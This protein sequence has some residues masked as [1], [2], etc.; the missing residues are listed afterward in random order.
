VKRQIGFWQKLR[1]TEWAFSKRAST[2]YG[3]S[4]SMMPARQR[5]PPRVLLGWAW[6]VQGKYCTKSACPPL[7]DARMAFGGEERAPAAGASSQSQAGSQTIHLSIHSRI[8]EVMVWLSWV[9]ELLVQA[10]CSDLWRNLLWL[11]LVAWKKY[12]EK[13]ILHHIKLTIHVWSTKCRWNQKLIIQLCCT[14]RD[15][16]FEPN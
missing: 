3:P 15:E 7:H 10:Q 14:L 8:N 9:Y 1:E 4:R 16:R 11:C 6:M 2:M 12:Y 13:K 5:I